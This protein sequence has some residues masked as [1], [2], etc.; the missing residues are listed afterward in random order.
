MAESSDS[1]SRVHIKTALR[2]KAQYA[3]TGTLETDQDSNIADMILF[4]ENMFYKGTKLP[5]ESS[6]HR[7]SF[8]EPETSI[9]I[10]SGDYAYDLP[11]GFSSFISPYLAYTATDAPYTVQITTIE[12][13]R[14]LHSGN[15]G[16][17]VDWP[18]HAALSLK[19]RAQSTGQRFELLLYPIPNATK[20]LIFSYYLNPSLTVDSTAPYPLGGQPHG[21]TLLTAC[22]AAWEIHMEDTVDGPNYRE[23]LRLMADSIAFDRSSTTP[24]HFG[25]NSDASQRPRRMIRKHRAFGTEYLGMS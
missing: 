12:R 7:W 3:L 13:L 6:I 25:K 4:G 19:T 11:D 5:G 9:T 15:S 1:L 10:S 2:R 18:T 17:Q 16:Q 8:L 14:E 20:T 24:Q 22:L 21:L 23:F